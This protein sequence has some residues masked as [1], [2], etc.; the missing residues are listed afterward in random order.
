MP[1]GGHPFDLSYILKA[2]GR[3]NRAGEYGCLYTATDAATARAEHDKAL[4]RAGAA[5]LARRHELVRF[6]VEVDPVLDLIDRGVRRR[7]SVT[8]A[9]LT[10]DDDESL[11]A[12]RRVADWA[13]SDGHA[14]ILAPSAARRDGVVLALYPDAS[15]RQLDLGHAVH[16]EPL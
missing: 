7:L 15:A 16:R 9:A 8:K 12:C 10:G 3:W 4:A 1:V 2:A 13:R 6:D 11:E 14:A 5:G